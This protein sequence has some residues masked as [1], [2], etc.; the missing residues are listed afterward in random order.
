VYSPSFCFATRSLHVALDDGPEQPRHA[1]HEIGAQHP[2]PLWRHQRP[3]NALCAPQRVHRQI[4]LADDKLREFT[5]HS[6]GRAT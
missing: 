4:A 5:S 3:K 2:A 1:L 6:A